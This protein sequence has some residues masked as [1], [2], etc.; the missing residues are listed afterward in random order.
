VGHH[1]ISAGRKRYAISAT[2]RGLRPDWLPE[3][4]KWY[5]V[6]L[7]DRRSVA[8]LPT[9]LPYVLHLASETVPS[10]F[11]NYGPLVESVEMTLNLCRHLTA[12]RLVLASSCLVYA[13]SSRPID[14]DAPLNPRGNYG[15]A[16][17]LGEAVVAQMSGGAD[18]VVARPFNHIGVGMRPDLAI[19]SIVR[20]V[21]AARAGDSIKMNGLDSVR[22]F[23]DVADIVAA[24]FALLDLPDRPSP[25]FNVASGQGVSISD[26]VRMVARVLDKPIGEIVFAAQGNSADD[27]L[28]IV[29]DARRLREATG[30]APSIGIEDSLRQLAGATHRC[31][32]PACGR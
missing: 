1:V 25:V 31:L 12:G 14:E 22:D 9:G 28:S 6:D 2:G 26:I 20:R 16:K 24:Y 11:T 19:P 17:A 5:R 4:V 27:T 29:G 18:G 13:A 7:L 32:A 21:R 10:R 3:D 23:L 15:L 30:W 8:T